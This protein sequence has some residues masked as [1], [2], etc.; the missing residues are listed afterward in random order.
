MHGCKLDHKWVRFT[1][2]SVLGGKTPNVLVSPVTSNILQTMECYHEILLTTA[3]SYIKLLTKI[4][5]IC[6]LV[7]LEMIRKPEG[8]LK[9]PYQKVYWYSHGVLKENISPK[10]MCDKLT[11]KMYHIVDY[12]FLGRLAILKKEVNK[13][14]SYKFYI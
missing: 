9:S 1:D 3:M 5:P 2:I 12:F 7:T 8:F 11:Q 13:L 4:Q 6:F 14:K 10:C